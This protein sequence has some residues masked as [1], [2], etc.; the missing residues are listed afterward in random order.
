MFL[1]VSV[2]LLRVAKKVKNGRRKNRRNQK[3]QS[4]PIKKSETS[5]RTE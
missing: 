5:S 2:L 3:L 4:M 1:I